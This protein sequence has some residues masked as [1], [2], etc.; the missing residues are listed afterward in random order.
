MNTRS[1]Q[2]LNILWLGS[3]ELDNDHSM[4]LNDAVGMERPEQM[5]AGVMQ[6]ILHIDTQEHSLPVWHLESP[7]IE[8]LD[9]ITSQVDAL[10]V[11][12]LADDAWI[13][14]S[15][16]VPAL[17]FN[18]HNRTT[19]HL[20]Q[21]NITV[22]KSDSETEFLSQIFDLWL[23]LCQTQKANRQINTQQQNRMLERDDARLGLAMLGEQLIEISEHDD[24]ASHLHERI[25]ALVSHEM[26]TPLNGIV[27]MAELMAE[28]SLDDEQSEEIRLIH[29]SASKLAELV[30]R[31]L[32][33]RSINHSKLSI[34]ETDFDLY[35]CIESVIERMIPQA[36]GTG[37]LLYDLIDRS[38]PRYV[39]G[40]LQILS[41]I[42]TS[43]ISNA[44]KFTEKGQVIVH[45]SCL[46]V[47][48][49]SDYL[50][51]KVQD[52]GIGIDPKNMQ[53]IFKPFG[54]IEDYHT[55]KH[56]GLGIGLCVASQMAKQLD[57][58]ILVESKIGV[59]SIF[60]LRIPLKHVS[61]RVENGVSIW[62][63]I[64]NTDVLIWSKNQIETSAMS[65]Q[66]IQA[67][68]MPTTVNSVKQLL[69]HLQNLKAAQSDQ[70]HILLMD[71]HACN[72]VPDE[73]ISD[74]LQ[75]QNITATCLSRPKFDSSAICGKTCPLN[76]C[77]HTS[78]IHLQ[79]K[80]MQIIGDLC[81][82]KQNYMLT[83]HS[84]T[85]SRFGVQSS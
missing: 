15:Q 71:E 81:Q 36:M 13:Q 57:G 78:G 64:Q 79:F 9:Q 83:E 40:D 59:G 26:R 55:R 69:S 66:M 76:A 53:S 51:I 68:C 72:G 62:Q 45:V 4:H 48:S 21:A 18:S 52:T 29:Q 16:W 32:D 17:Y 12:N 6:K 80:L 25:L 3:T 11:H 46:P 7:T 74:I 54:Q 84:S 20:Q 38:T 75:D 23:E 30:D 44:I 61:K 27:G 41:K 77:R 37:L 43:L 22:V 28:S 73:Q 42:L 50:E 60:T 85:P 70:R 1:T 2:Q 63:Q 67:G 49:E 65:R 56:E 5:P 58:E 8:L 31:L 19:D 34:H 10:I 47:V 33:Y 82:Q 35:E 39:R 24:E 14:L